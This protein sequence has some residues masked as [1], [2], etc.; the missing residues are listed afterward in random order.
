VTGCIFVSLIV[1]ALM[2]DTRAQSAMNRH[3]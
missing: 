3:Y 2:R 1:Y